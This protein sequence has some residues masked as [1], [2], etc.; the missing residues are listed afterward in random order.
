MRVRSVIAGVLWLVASCTKPNPARQCMN[1]ICT[2]PDYPFCD[3]TGFVT[4]EPGICVAVSCT[5]GELAE[6]RGAVEVRCNSS[7]ANYD[8]IQ[9]QLGCDP[10]S[11]G[12]RSCL[13]NE[14]T[15]TNGTV[16]SCDAN[17]AV[18][19]KVPC[20]LGCFEDEPR[21]RDIAPSNGF[22]SYLDMVDDP[23]DLDLSSGGTITTSSGQISSAA[24]TPID[25]PSFLIPAPADGAEVRLFIAKRVRLGDVT[26][27]A[28]TPNWGRGPALAIVATD[29]ITVE[30]T[31]DLTDVDRPSPG[32]VAF[33]SC[34]GKWG[35]YEPGSQTIISGSGGGGHATTGAAGGNVGETK[36][37]GASGG[38]SGT[39]TLVPLRGGCSSGEVV[40]GGGAVQLSS[41]TRVLVSGTINANGGM[42]IPFQDVVAG[43]GAGGGILLEAPTVELG[44]TAKLL[45]NGGA[46]ASIHGSGT[47][48]LTLAPATGGVCNAASQY[49][50]NGGNGAA[51]GIPATN[52]GSTS[53]SSLPPTIGSG[54]GGGG[55]GRIRVNTRDG[56][57]TKASSA[58]E[59]G[60]ITTGTI[61]TR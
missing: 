10:T 35:I 27:T 44:I 45:A 25:V 22:A 16:A 9:C 19:A 3:L 48:S 11:E 34:I 14:T 53:Y 39:D 24:S 30:G 31:L 61:A 51:V 26:V 20:P 8:V 41:R 18:I 56:T 46:G 59:A 2:S 37:G 58:I 4:G 36:L 55:L 29:E 38:A 6:C 32:G 52:G 17:G 5:P 33:A 23:P 40:T 28:D 21:C 7:G 12:C 57:Y 13:P 60:S 54:G 47:M 50:G 15:C 43:G 42:G 49:C 1:G